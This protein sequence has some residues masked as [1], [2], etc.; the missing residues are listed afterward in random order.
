MPQALAAL[1]TVLAF[2]PHGNRIDFQLDHGAAELIWLSPSTFH[3][4]RT[5]KGPLAP[6]KPAAAPAVALDIDDTPAALRIRSTF[7][8]VTIR[9]RGALVRVRALD[10]SSL[11]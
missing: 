10:G 5:L 9:K 1:A 8:E 6:G 2:A 3:F 4:R 11:L 7:V